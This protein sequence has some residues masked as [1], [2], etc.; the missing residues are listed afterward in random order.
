MAP[1]TRSFK[2]ARSRHPT[3]EGNSAAKISDSIV[4]ETVPGTAGGAILFSPQ[5]NP[6]R[7]LQRELR[8]RAETLIHGRVCLS[9]NPNVGIDAETISEVMASREGAE[10]IVKALARGVMAEA[11][12]LE[13]VN[14]ISSEEA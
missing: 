7:T 2:S 12:I 14:K 4:T 1:R 11:L 8:Q 13:V 9:G 10:I 6:L 3:I 5:E